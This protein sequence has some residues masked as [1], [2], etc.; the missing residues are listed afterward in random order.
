[1]DGE[2]LCAFQ[3]VDGNEH[4]SYFYTRKKM[5]DVLILES[6]KKEKSRTSFSYYMLTVWESVETFA[7]YLLIYVRCE[8]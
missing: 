1:M 8:N 5:D 2:Q 7:L 6:V 4:C 3:D